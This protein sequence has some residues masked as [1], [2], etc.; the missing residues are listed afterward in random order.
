[1]D[2]S[3]DRTHPALIMH[4]LPL[5]RQIA[6]KSFLKRWHGNEWMQLQDDWMENASLMASCGLA[7]Y[8]FNAKRI[9]YCGKHGIF[10]EQTDFCRRCCLDDRVQPALDEYGQ[11]FK[12]APYWYAMVANTR[13]R[14]NEAGLEFGKLT[15]SPYTG[16]VDGH[17]LYACPEQEPVFERLCQALFALPTFLK[18][19]GVI[20]GAFCQLEFHLSFQTGDSLY[21]SWSSLQHAVQPHLNIL[22]NTT[23]PITSEVAL[24]MYTL[25]GRLLMSHDARLSYPNLWIQQIESQQALNGWLRYLLKP[26]PIAQWYRRARKRGCNPT[27]LNLLFDEI[28]F[29]NLKH[30]AGRVVSPRKMGNLNCQ[31]RSGT[32]I[33]TKRPMDLSG[34][35]VSRWLKDSV[36]AALHPDWEDSV[37]QLIEKRRSRQGQGQNRTR[38]SELEMED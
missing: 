35:E 19:H 37:Y 30:L 27:S 20:T 32:Y 34:K 7:Q 23:V 1:M 4:C 22:V 29:E 3:I 36:F 26:W 15:H 2:A 33:G 8:I 24:A 9:L 10:C 11:C 31:C 16:K 12:S 13:I 38:E 14:A 21:D 25:L 18:K 6:L 5:D 17:I 28:V